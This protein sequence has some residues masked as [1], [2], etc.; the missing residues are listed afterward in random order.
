MDPT[1]QRVTSEVIKAVTNE[2]TTATLARSETLKILTLLLT[3]LFYKIGAASTYFTTRKRQFEKNGEQHSTTLKT[4][5]KRQC[6]HNV[7]DKTTYLVYVL[8]ILIP[9]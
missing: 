3:T 5:R 8:L 7:C 1:N 9:E 6:K 2:D 4:Q